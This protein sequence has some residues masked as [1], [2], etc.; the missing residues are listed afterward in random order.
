M[1]GEDQ[2]TLIAD[3]VGRRIWAVVGVSQN[4]T[5]FGYRIF[6]NLREAGYRVYGVN[7][8]AQ[9]V[10]G[11][12]IY[13]S[14]ESLPERPEVIDVVVPPAAT[15]QV[16][17]DCAR[18]GLRRVWLQPGAESPAAVA[19]CRAHGIAV[20]YDACAMVEKKRW[21]VSRGLTVR[22]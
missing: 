2:A 9:Q 16:I 10:D 19:Y 1:P 17:Q 12:T 5:K 8:N 13:P 4:P 20:V 6:R 14:L 15:E 22:E 3:F 21:P 18:L 7:P 11:Q